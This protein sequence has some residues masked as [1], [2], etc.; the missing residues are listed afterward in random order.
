MPNDPWGKPYVYRSPGEHGAYDIISSARTARKA[1]LAQQPTSPAGRAERSASEG[2]FTLIEILC[3]LAIIALLAAIMLPAIPRGTSRARLE[4]YAVRDRGA[5]Q[6]R[7]QR[8]DAPRTAGGDRGRRAGAHDPLGRHRPA[9]PAA[10]RCALRRDARRALQSARGGLA[11]SISSRP[12][13][14]AAASIALARPGIGYEIRVNWLTGGVE[15]V[16]LNTL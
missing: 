15:I 8:G 4:A 3:V 6:G 16:P 9:H 10:G 7:P 1:A 14:R 2:G 11:R 12:A 5:A 13:C